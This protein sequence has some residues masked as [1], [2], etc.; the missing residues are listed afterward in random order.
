MQRAGQ[1]LLESGIQ[2]ENGG[3][4][5]YYRTDNAQ[6]LPHSTEITGYALSGFCYL[7]ELTGDER[8]LEAAKRSARFLTDFAW[9][10]ES[11]TMPFELEGGRRFSYFFDC[12]IVSRGLLWLWRLN[13][14]EKCLHVARAVGESMER[15]FRGLTS[16][17]PIIWLPCKSPEPYAIWWSKMP[18]AFQLKSALAWLD[19]AGETGEANFAGLFDEMLLFALRR[20]SETLDNEQDRPKLMDRLH[21]WAYF[22]EGLQPVRKRPEVA[23]TI[24]GALDRAE[25]LRDEL[26]G[27]F[28]RSDVCSQLLRV[29]LLQGGQASAAER[30][31]IESFQVETSDVRLSGGFGFGRRNSE[32]TPHANPVSTVFAIQALEMARQAAEGKLR[33]FDWRKLI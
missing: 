10:P 14:D 9:D 8:Y 3:V 29:C 24:P 4:A 1:W 18:G 11:K 21:A 30:E 31:R 6:Y 19:L 25:K 32:A 26:Q 33:E 17:H 16:F 5:R 28:L 12:G 2:A 27:E 23:K 20:Y 22:L 13:R 15:D 7:F